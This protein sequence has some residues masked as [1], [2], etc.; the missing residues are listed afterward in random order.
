M[1]GKELFNESQLHIILHLFTFN[2]VWGKLGR[3][4][5]LASWLIRPPVIDLAPIGCNSYNMASLAI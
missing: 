4:G 5:A 3:G 2:I 1:V